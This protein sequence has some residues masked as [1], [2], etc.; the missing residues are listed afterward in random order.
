MS[1]QITQPVNQV[2]LTNV[3][4]VRM[5]THGKR[6]EIA[7]YRNK[8][9][10]YRQGIETDLEETLQTD[11]IFTNVSKGQFAKSADLK[12][13]FGTTNEEEICKIILMKG[14][15]QV[16]DMERSAQL[17]ATTKEVA[18]MLAAKCVDPASN[19]PYTVSQIRDAMQ[20]A[21]FCVHPTR[22]VKQQF[23]DCVK[24]IKSKGF[25]PIERAKME[26]CVVCDTA[27]HEDVVRALEEAGVVS[28]IDVRKEG[29]SCDLVILVDPSVFRTVDTIA[30][31]KEI[32][33]PR[34]RL[35][36]LQQCVTAEGDVNLASEVERKNKISCRK[37]GLDG[38]GHTA[39]GANEELDS[40]IAALAKETTRAISMKDDT[41][42]NR[43]DDAG[44]DGISR[45]V[46]LRR[47]NKKAQKKSKKA[48]RRE[49]EE[50]VE[51]QARV[52]AEKARQAERAARLGLD[53]DV[54]S[55][56]G[57]GTN[58]S[59]VDGDTKSCNTCGGAF[60]PAQ[61]RAHFRSDW[62]RYNIKLKMS[63]AA[64]VSEEEFK[65]DVGAFF[66]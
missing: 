4:V 13:C 48:K 65:R 36:I 38:S 61:Y 16:S 53:A 50:A 15:V 59:C 46:S 40:D 8:I 62:H 14:S 12:K 41:E 5:Q 3:A 66:E 42:K 57:P 6:F 37:D 19:R 54:A 1:R 28:N 33:G 27:K 47:S 44:E 10:N 2:R 24:L 35:E 58:E 11:R 34:G 52:D 31:D 55:T 45:P 25:L 22:S 60:S 26:L 9:V 18:S 49:K 63:G 21:E 29:D 32:C 20:R 23:L 30:K 51:R 39:D 7:C 17:E 64:I 43:N 56:R